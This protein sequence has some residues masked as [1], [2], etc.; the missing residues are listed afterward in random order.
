MEVPAIWIPIDPE[1]SEI[2]EDLEVRPTYPDMYDRPEVAEY[3]DGKFYI[4]YMGTPKPL[5]PDSWSANNFMYY[6]NVM[7]R[8]K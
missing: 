7:F 3:K 1:T 5:S 2:M 6:A 8:D 4:T